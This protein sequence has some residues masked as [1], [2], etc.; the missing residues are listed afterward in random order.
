MTDDHRQ[1][2]F[3]EAP[4]HCSATNLDGWRA[5]LGSYPDYVV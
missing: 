1:L 5:Y 3:D 2:I 4:V